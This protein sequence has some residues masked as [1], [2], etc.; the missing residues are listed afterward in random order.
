MRRLEGV[1]HA[2]SYEVDFLK[3][4]SLF[5]DRLHVHGLSGELDPASISEI[6]FLQ[7]RG[8]VQII[9]HKELEEAAHRTFRQVDLDL[10]EKAVKASFDSD[11]ISSFYFYIDVAVRL[12]SLSLVQSHSDTDV[13]PICR[14]E[15]AKLFEEQISAKQ[16]VLQVAMQQFPVP[17]EMSAWQDIF[18]FKREMHDQQWNF[19]RFMGT[20]ATK[21]QTEAEIRDD[22]EWTLN[23]Y[24]K[25]MDRF[26]VKRSVSF[27]ETY[28]IPTVE[29]FES[30]KPSSFLKGLVSMKK[31]KIELLEGEAK[32]PGRE[33]AYIFEARK[34]FK[35]VGLS[36][37]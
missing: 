17:G 33:C 28:I 34:R 12:M 35:P 8:F 20:L 27:M 5:F 14:G 32:A 13:V 10:L 30:F 23:E 26:K 22:I 4:Y 21:K 2:A 3:Q 36:V 24:T 31:R 29:A 6:S 1:V 37:A 11:G 16:N 18:E 9:E 15:F 7:E 25:E 19:R